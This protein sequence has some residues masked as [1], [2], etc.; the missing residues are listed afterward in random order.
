M[1]GQS[2]TLSPSAYSLP[3][4]PSAAP[5]VGLA[6]QPQADLSQ[7][8]H[9]QL[10]LALSRDIPTADQPQPELE[11]G[12]E[13]VNS[14]QPKSNVCVCSLMFCLCTQSHLQTPAI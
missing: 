14:D 4:G 10:G 6:E 2:F 7:C 1:N 3:L 12:P 11:P 13:S 9:K 5:W 8:V